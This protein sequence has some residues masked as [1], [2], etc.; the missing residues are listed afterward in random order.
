MIGRSD[1]GFAGG[2]LP[3]TGEMRQHG[4]QPTWLG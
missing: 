4:A 1:G 2:V 3:L